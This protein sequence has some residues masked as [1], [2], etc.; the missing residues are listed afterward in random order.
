MTDVIDV[1]WKLLGE[2]WPMAVGEALKLSISPDDDARYLGRLLHGS[3]IEMTFGFIQVYSA[4]IFSAAPILIRVAYEALADQQ[5]LKCNPQYAVNIKAAG[6]KTGTDLPELMAFGNRARVQDFFAQP[7]TSEF[8]R[9]INTTKR[10]LDQAGGRRLEAKAKFSAAGM[11][12]EY[13]FF[14]CLSADVHNDLSTLLSRHH[15]QSDG[16]L[17]I[18]QARTEVERSQLLDAAFLTLVRSCRLAHDKPDLFADEF[19]TYARIV[20]KLR[21]A[22]PNGNRFPHLEKYTEKP[23]SCADK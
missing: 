7:G 11:E 2:V 18:F 15:G 8:Q 3:V 9:S 20:S 13:L 10:D 14:N 4:A 16:L 19:G 6:I 1:K 5:A 23:E 17:G 21:A 12:T 22:D